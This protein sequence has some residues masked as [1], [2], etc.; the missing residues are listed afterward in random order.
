MKTKFTVLFLLVFTLTSGVL[1][2][3]VPP[4][5]RW[6]DY[7]IPSGYA[8][9][10][11][12]LPVPDGSVIIA[13]RFMGDS[14]TFGTTTLHGTGGGESEAVFIVRYGK[15]G[16]VIWAKSVYCL[17][18]E[19]ANTNLLHLH[20]QPDLSP[21]LILS[22]SGDRLNLPDGNSLALPSGVNVNAFIKLDLVSG[23]QTAVN[24]LWVQNG[25]ADITSA[26]IDKEGNLVFA[27]TASG[28]SIYWTYSA[29]EP[30]ALQG[31]N[32]SQAYIV[33]FDRSL[34]NPLWYQ[35]WAVDTSSESHAQVVRIDPVNQ[36]V[37]TGG[38][39]RGTINSGK[40]DVLT[41]TNL[42]DIFLAG[43]DKD[44]K[45]LFVIQGSGDGDDFVDNVVFDDAGNYYVAG[46][47]SSQTITFPGLEVPGL[48]GGLFDVFGLKFAKE[49]LAQ[50][51]GS[52]ILN[53]MLDYYD[54]GYTTN[55][56][57]YIK[58]N[59]NILW[60]TAFKSNTFTAGQ[61]NLPKVTPIGGPNYT[62]YAVLCL[63]SES[64]QFLW[65]QNFGYNVEYPQEFN[66]TL[67]ATG[68]YFAFPLQEYYNLYFT[69]GIIL[70]N[71]VMGSTGFVVAH[72]GMDGS[73]K[74]NKLILPAAVYDY[75][76]V[77]GIG[78]LRTGNILIAGYYSG[79]API[80]LD[81]NVL[82]STSYGNNFFAAT[83]GYA[84]QG[85]VY[86]PA[87]HPITKGVV[88]L[89]GITSDTRGIE[90]E[91]VD[92]SS[93]GKYTFLSA[94]SSGF[95]IYAEPDPQLYPD[96]MGTYYGDVS[97][98]INIPSVDMSLSN[99][100][101]FDIYLNQRPALTG[102][103][104]ADGSVEFADD[105]LSNVTKRLK[106]IQGKPVKSASVVLVGRTKANGE[107]IIAQTYTDEN[108]FF[109]FSNIPDG[110]YT[111]FVDLPGYQHKQFFDLDVVGGQ[112]VTGINYQVTEDG[113]ILRPLAVESRL[114]SQEFSV[115]PNPSRGVV[116]LSS[117]KTGNYLIEVYSVSGQK[118][119][120][121]CKELNQ[122]DSRIDL[123]GLTPG[124]YHLRVSGK[125]SVYNTKLI[126][127]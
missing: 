45:K 111:V 50:P 35:L 54:P 104:A 74:Y 119:Y 26:D 92:V 117:E 70:S 33:K 21:V 78:L 1:Q 103:N 89:F 14:V 22:C 82:P 46:A 58:D 27:G 42:N 32:I 19:W 34:N 93:N 11:Q 43:Y 72:I 51:F 40:G 112:N 115:Y 79:T 116:S 48:T 20:L 126:I 102:N 99:L 53:T 23:N 127:Q 118:V 15:D 123:T 86:T 68:A 67:T 41:S 52:V 57:R 75:L 25:F 98:W 5:F 16:T 12:V 61:L 107:N 7:A 44:G 83:L 65:G 64:G 56:F 69:G 110:S 113:I 91:K 87:H 62:E 13:G 8:M 10:S 47:S 122:G 24:Y 76:N 59:G 9:P 90:I 17:S 124:L 6:S 18:Q 73:L 71:T 63:N 66:Y 2:S 97:R 109:S 38:H 100:S 121:L 81:E 3:Q 96:L 94:P 29:L 80:S 55:K 4:S 95:A 39:F 49:N 37:I 28:D 125:N 108:G 77:T 85:T 105:Y 114:A 31:G 120:S 30:V 88:K 36:N 60:L 106:S 101:S 84:I